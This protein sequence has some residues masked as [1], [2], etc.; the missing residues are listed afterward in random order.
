MTFIQ[1]PARLALGLAL[2]AG[3]AHTHI[4][5]QVGNGDFSN[6]LSGWAATGDA[7]VFNG[8]L[9]LSTAFVSDG[10][11][12]APFNLSGQDAA[13]IDDLAAATGTP[14]TAFDLAGEEALEGSVVRQ[15]FAVAAGQTLRFDWGFSTR[16]TVFQ[17][18]AFVAIDGQVFTLASLAT[19]PAGPQAFNHLFTQGGSVMLA[20]GVVDTGDVLGVSTLS[21]DNVQLSAVPEPGAWALMA[22][23]LALLAARRRPGR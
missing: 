19:A 22:G 4:H 11:E 21:I 3:S 14:V 12:D 9:Q 6:G 17:D 10:G 1:N 7:A 15:S 5:A 2:L 8:V 23:G 16:E 18:H 20:F 13:W